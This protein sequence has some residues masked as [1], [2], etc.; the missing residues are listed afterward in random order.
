MGRRRP[1]ASD[2]ETGRSV[3]VDRHCSPYSLADSWASHCGGEIWV[4]RMD[5]E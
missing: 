1:V 2:V 5:E 4:R 3:G